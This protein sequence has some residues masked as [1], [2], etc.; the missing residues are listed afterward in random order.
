MADI[1][2]LS[3]RQPWGWAIATGLK[4]VENRSWHTNYRGPVAIH[5]SGTIDEYARMPTDQ[6]IRR[7]RAVRAEAILAQQLPASAKYLRLSRILAVADLVDIHPKYHICNPRGVPSTVCS[8]WA[9]WGE[10]H[11]ILENVR[12][13]PEPV[14]CKGRLGLW[15]LPEDVERAVREQLEAGHA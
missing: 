12:P 4:P 14:P 15:K 10:Q 3:V 7:L 5:A 11:W 6:A 13:L 2:G 9:V 1:L 8:P